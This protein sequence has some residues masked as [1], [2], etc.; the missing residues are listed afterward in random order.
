M[1]LPSNDPVTACLWIASKCNCACLTLQRIQFIWVVSVHSKMHTTYPLHTSI[2][3]HITEWV[4]A[5]CKNQTEV[6]NIPCGPDKQLTGFRIQR[7]VCVC[8]CAC[9]CVFFIFI[10]IMHAPLLWSNT[11]CNGVFLNIPCGPDK[12]LTRPCIQQYVCV[13]VCVLLS[14]HNISLDCPENRMFHNQNHVNV[15]DKTVP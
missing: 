15:L 14:F 1:S 2:S 4:T 9:V 11:T 5:F 10:F 6:I 3:Q 12:Q 13:C 7:C 8:V